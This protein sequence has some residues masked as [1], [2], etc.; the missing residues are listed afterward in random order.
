MKFGVLYP[1]TGI[2]VDKKLVTSFAIEAERNNFDFLF[3]WDHYMTPNSNVWFE[4]WSLLSYLSSVTSIIKLG[5]CVT[6]IPFRNPSQLAKIVANVDI[7]SEGRVILGAGA[8]WAKEEFDA[9]SK[10]EE[11]STRVSMTE[12]GINLI[13]KLWTEDEVNFE[14][15]F[16]KSLRARL[17]PK[18]IQKPHPP[19]W[20]ASFGKRMLKIASNYG[21]GWIPTQIDHNEYL[22]LKNEIN[23]TLRNENFQYSYNLFRPFQTIDEYFQ[24]IEKFEKVG[25]RNFIINW[26][27]KPNEMIDKLKWF[28]DNVISCK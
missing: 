16:Y 17:E 23:S 24:I 5:T 1:N 25:C 11:S 2:H 13:L 22:Y 27:Y 9:Y 6:P 15:K 19:I 20:L 18:P 10:W 4:A 21:N 7:L 14:G 12:E 26:L 28:K 3:I 8:G